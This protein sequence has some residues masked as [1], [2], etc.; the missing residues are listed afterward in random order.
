[1][2]DVTKWPLAFEL[3]GTPVTK[4]IYVGYLESSAF[5][6][7]VVCSFPES[8]NSMAVVLD[9][10]RHDHDRVTYLFLAVWAKIPANNRIDCYLLVNPV[11]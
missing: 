1:M 8:M 3:A 7:K 9:V 11:H 10:I 6:K 2:I 4:L 5:N